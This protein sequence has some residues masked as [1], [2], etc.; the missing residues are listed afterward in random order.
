M[1]DAGAALMLLEKDLDGKRLADEIRALLMD[2]GR[3]TE[4]ERAASRVGRPEAAREI[5]DV[6]FELMSRRA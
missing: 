1:V 5:V 2:R 3:I 4:M 6:C